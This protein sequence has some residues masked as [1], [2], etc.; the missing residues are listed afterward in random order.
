M[1]TPTVAQIMTTG[2]LVVCGPRDSVAHATHA[3]DRAGVRHLPVVDSERKVVG[4]VS[5]RDL[6]SAAQDA[7]VRDVMSQAVH[8]VA[9]ETSASEAAYLLWQRELE[10]LPVT[11]PDGELI[12]LVTESDFVRLAY[13][14][15][16]GRALVD[17][18]AAEDREA[19]RS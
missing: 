12:G 6:A 9:A 7:P 16:G 1:D 17:D 4:V 14:L 13:T 8:A 19:D 3:M 18:L 15:L 10:C 11:T 2:E 5:R